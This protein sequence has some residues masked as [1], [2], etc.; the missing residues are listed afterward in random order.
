MR[1][2]ALSSHERKYG[3]REAIVGSRSPFSLRLERN[4]A[5]R[6]TERWQRPQNLVTRLEKLV[7]TVDN[8]WLKNSLT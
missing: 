2:S 5:G 3:E 4:E 8:V 1:E 6:T 7:L